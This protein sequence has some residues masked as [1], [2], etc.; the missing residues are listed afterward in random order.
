MSKDTFDDEYTEEPTTDLPELDP[1]EDDIQPIN[2][3]SD[4]IEYK[5]PLSEKECDVASNIYF[6]LSEYIEKQGLP[7]GQFLT[8]E[9][10][11]NFLCGYQP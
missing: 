7:I 8:T 11:Y 6:E 9:K 5:Q 2:N 3:E 4:V 10:M 1:Y